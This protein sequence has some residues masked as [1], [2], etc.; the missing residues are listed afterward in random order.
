M[1]PALVIITITTLIKPLKGI[2]LYQIRADG[3][4]KIPVVLVAA[5]GE[6]SCGSG[7]T[8]KKYRR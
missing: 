5:V 2:V 8:F 7:I 6:K 4:L 1:E 3:I